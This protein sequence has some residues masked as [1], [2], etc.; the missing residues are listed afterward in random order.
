MTEAKTCG[1]G[2]RED[3]LKQIG[4]RLPTWKTVTLVVA[5]CGSIATYYVVDKKDAVLERKEISKST[6][7]NRESLVSIG[8]TLD[9]LKKGQDVIDNKQDALDR[10]IDKVLRELPKNGNSDNR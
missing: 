8:V 1:T 7:T 9:Y 3:L 5:L 4:E 6:Q 2:C 10:K